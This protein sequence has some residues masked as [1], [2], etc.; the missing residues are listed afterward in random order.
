MNTEITSI[1]SPDG[2]LARALG[3]DYHPR[4]GQV[5]MVSRVWEALYTEQ[6]ALIEAG[7]G[8]GKSFAYLVPPILRGKR[9]IISTANK[10]LQTQLVEKD[11]P[12]LKRALSRP[13]SFALLKGRSNYICNLRLSELLLQPTITT[14]VQSLHDLN[15]A[16]P[17]QPSGDLERL[18]GGQKLR[19]DLTVNYEDCLKENCKFYAE[20][21]YEHARAE[22][23]AAQIV[24]LNHALLT[25]VLM[26]QTI[27]IRDIVVVDEAHELTAYMASALSKQITIRRFTNTLHSGAV[28]RTLDKDYLERVE[29]RSGRVFQQLYDE[30]MKSDGYPR[31][32]ARGDLLE[33]GR[34]LT[35][36]FQHIAQTIERK[37]PRFRSD[38]GEAKAR[39]ELAVQ[40][41]NNLADDA[42]RVFGDESD[43][44]VRYLKRIPGSREQ[45]SVSVNLQPVTVGDIIHELMF[46]NVPSVICTSATLSVDQSF[47]HFRDEVGLRPGMRVLE[48]MIS[49]PF[50][51]ERQA[52]LY[53]PRH[54]TPPR[55][56]GKRRDQIDR[57]EAAYIE[58]LKGEIIRLLE[59]SGGRALVLFTNRRRMHDFY[60]SLRGQI[61]FNCYV[62]DDTPK[63][64]NQ[65]SFWPSLRLTQR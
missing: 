42:A 3:R 54:L 36:D 20:C 56:K 57:E 25:R 16:L 18:P 64:E 49:S 32:L 40:C 24:V 41:A 58:A 52:L 48:R 2:P 38:Q 61:R 33:S 55:R 26:G 30:V 31:A 4:P 12:F 53:I 11:L 21:Y 37:S 50:D 46:R 28:Q 34:A 23:E 17:R 60:D 35:S 59:A 10:T 44:D 7:T 39:F 43:S 27:A 65:D 19:G 63:A 1:F 6:H 14:D 5:E 15:A 22:A 45:S 9:A 8:I 29:D 62:Q 51:F 13:F 47:S